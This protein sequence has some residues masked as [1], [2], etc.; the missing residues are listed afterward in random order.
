MQVPF[1]LCEPATTVNVGAKVLES[2]IIGFQ[3]LLY[4]YYGHSPVAGKLQEKFY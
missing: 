3:L 4:S 1:T 2:I